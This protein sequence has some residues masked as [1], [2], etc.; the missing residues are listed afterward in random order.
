[1]S[2]DHIYTR[3]HGTWIRTDQRVVDGHWETI[4]QAERPDYPKDFW[5]DL[6]QG[7]GSLVDERYYFGDLASALDFYTSGW[8]ERRYLDGN[9]QPLG[10]DHMGLYS[11]GRLVY[12]HSIHGDAPGHE[13]ENLRKVCEEVVKKM[14]EEEGQFE[15]ENELG[16]RSY[17][18]CGSSG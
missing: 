13:G 9:N 8:K 10:M 3:V 16:G 18:C 6:C 11:R 15:K 12:G 17:D 5:V 1:M 2:I 14:E 7:G 4:P